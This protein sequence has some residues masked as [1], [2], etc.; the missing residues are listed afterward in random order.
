MAAKKRAMN[1]EAYQWWDTVIKGIGFFVL[2]LTAGMGVW[3]YH[4]AQEREFK[5]AFYD[6][7]IDVVNEVFN[8]LSEV[9]SAS[10]DS[11][12]KSAVAKFWLIYHGKARTFLDSEMFQAL[13]TPAE[14]IASC[15]SK[16]HK[17]RNITCSNYSASMS[18]IG[19]ARVARK[20]LSGVW[21]VGFS[22]I[23]QEDPW[24]PPSE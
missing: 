4:Y 18:A 6:K 16:T 9:Q 5:K 8:V 19:F 17:P 1:Q 2:C 23:G 14:Y 22:D 12:R 21:S 20:Q 24:S 11:E 3:Q 10:T 7:E 15:V 13:Q